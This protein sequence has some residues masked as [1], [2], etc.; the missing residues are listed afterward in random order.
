[1]ADIREREGIGRAALANAS[2]VSE[3]IIRRIEEV[4]G[5]PRIELKAHLVTGL[6]SLLGSQRYRADDVF[7]GW[8]AHRRD[9]RG[10]TAPEPA[11]A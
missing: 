6:N 1:L 10:R 4:D 7:P 5:S 9:R 3:R 11:A 8:Q 2:G